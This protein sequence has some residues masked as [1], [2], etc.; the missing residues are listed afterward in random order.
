MMERLHS[1]ARRNLVAYLALGIA[2]AA[3]GSVAYSAIPDANS[4]IHG[5]YENASGVLRVIDT[6]A[7]GTCRGGETALDWNQKGQAGATGAQGP[8]GLA[9]TYGRSAGGPVA[10]PDP[11][12]KKTVVALTVPRGSYVITGKAVGSLTVPGFS[13]EPGTLVTYCVML[14]NERRLAST[15][16]GCTVE[17]GT[18]S[19]LGRANLIAGAN[20]LKAFQTVSANVLHTFQGAS[21]KISLTCVQYAGGKWP[22][23]ITNARLI[24]MKV[25]QINPLNA[26]RAVSIKVPKAKRKPRLRSAP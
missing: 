16:F 20:Q 24:A 10:L 13:C 8:P 22:A 21:N 4:V 19:D 3:T 11:G 9:T 1:H 5:C 15:I 26:F 14:H 7:S 2:L 18:S 25:D 17:A 12:K 23:K 6:E